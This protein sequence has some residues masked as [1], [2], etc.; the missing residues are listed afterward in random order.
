MKKNHTA[1]TSIPDERTDT[2]PLRM[3]HLAA[4]FVYAL[5]RRIG[6][7][8]YY[9]LRDQQGVSYNEATPEAKAEL[10][11]VIGM[12][13]SS[14]LLLEQ[15]K[16]SFEKFYERIGMVI[17]WTM[18]SA[19]TPRNIGT[20]KGYTDFQDILRKAYNTAT[21]ETE[22]EELSA[23]LSVDYDNGDYFAGR[24]SDIISRIGRRYSLKNVNY[25]GLMT[26]LYFWDSTYDSRE[27][28]ART[29]FCMRR[30]ITTG[31][32]STAPPA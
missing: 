9:V 32:E 5:K 18:Y 16:R 2:A 13:P 28:W 24:F 31:A 29:M 17:A 6:T 19:V 11:K 4:E 8:T 25:I 7:N 21:S 30:N 22:K 26:D 15:N 20:I 3:D 12:C 10:F 23:I 14:C 27:K 1:K